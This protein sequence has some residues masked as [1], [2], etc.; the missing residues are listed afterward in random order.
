M[1]NTEDICPL[2]HSQLKD[3][4]ETKS[5]KKLQRC[6]KSQWNPT[7]RQTEGCLYVKWLNDDQKV[8]KE[9]CP[10]CGS[11]LVLQKTRSGK[12]MKKCATAGWDKE[13]MVATGCDYVEWIDDSR[14]ELK[15]DCPLCGA[16]LVEVKTS[17]GKKMKKCSTAGWDREFRQ[18]TGCT[19]I[20]W[21]N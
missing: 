14:K 21:I 6:S 20:Q 17:G 16:K 18:A 2:C 1:P 3:V 7:T 13:N 11:S 15:E 9:N 10:K 8:L 12:K 4:E 19:F 5:G